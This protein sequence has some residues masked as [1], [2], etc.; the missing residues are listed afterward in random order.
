MTYAKP[1]REGCQCSV[2]KRLRFA[3]TP[4]G[5]KVPPSLEGMFNDLC[6]KLG[7][8]EARRVMRDH[9]LIRQIELEV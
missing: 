6:D 3:Y 9:C 5:W 4:Y 1:L 8:A 7:Y 2:C